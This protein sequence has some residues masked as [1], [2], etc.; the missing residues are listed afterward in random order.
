MPDEEFAE[1]FAAPEI[2]IDGFT[3]HAVRDGVMTCIGYRNMP[4]GRHVVLR[5]AW[6]MVNTMAAVEEAEK[7]AGSK[8]GV[9]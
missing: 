8:R 7:D 2:Y 1:P 9:H 4:D 6:P 3:H 5:L